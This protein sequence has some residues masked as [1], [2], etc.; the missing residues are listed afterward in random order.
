MQDLLSKLENTDIIVILMVIAAVVVFELVLFFII[1]M[2][3]K[4]SKTK[5]ITVRLFG[6]VPVRGLRTTDRGQENQ[7]GFT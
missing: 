1:K 4:K 3:I 7:R 5:S 2:I 6:I